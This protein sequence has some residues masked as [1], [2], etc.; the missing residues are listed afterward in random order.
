MYSASC[1]QELMR[2][3]GSIVM[4]V[5]EVLASWQEGSRVA[6]ET[7]VARLRLEAE[8]ETLQ[9]ELERVTLRWR[10]VESLLQDMREGA[11]EQREKERAEK[12]LLSSSAAA[13]E[14]ERAE[15]RERERGRA[16][17]LKERV[18]EVQGEREQEREAARVRVAELMGEVEALKGEVERGKRCVAELRD[19]HRLEDDKMARAKQ[20][21]ESLEQGAKAQEEEQQRLRDTLKRVEEE[22]D[23]ALAS[24]HK[25]QEE[26]QKAKSSA[27]LIAASA[28][29][30]EQVM[31]NLRMITLNLDR[32]FDA[33]KAP[34]LKSPLYTIA[35]KLGH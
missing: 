4:V 16:E 5:E 21:T 11:T 23:Q 1:F 26:L 18:E 31:A 25:L 22:R 30:V 6:E 3:C 10:E 24:N 12:E 19:M 2:E 35:N 27:T 28:V 32:D 9:E 33:W 8:V 13:A 20:V 17:R 14:M 29:S 34:L 15:E 7:A